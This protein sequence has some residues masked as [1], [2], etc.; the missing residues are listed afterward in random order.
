MKSLEE[1]IK[2]KCKFLGNSTVPY[3]LY[4]FMQP[5][6]SAH[7][8]NLF[9]TNSNVES[10][11]ILTLL[12]EMGPL[13]VYIYSCLK[14]YDISGSPVL[15]LH[16]KF[17]NANLEL[18]ELFDLNGIFYEYKDNPIVRLT[19]TIN[20]FKKKEVFILLLRNHLG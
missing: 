10:E 20:W 17:Q 4:N 13:F 8:I 12:E 15:D 3:G 11:N 1:I 16:L 14:Y 5:T 9:L 18:D 19:S 6:N 7:V 2:Q